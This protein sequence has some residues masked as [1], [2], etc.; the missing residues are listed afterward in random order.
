MIE[1]ILIIAIFA[2]AI[3]LRLST[4]FYATRDGAFSDPI[5]RVYALCLRNPRSEG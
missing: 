4:F 5:G 2:V 3:G 1:I